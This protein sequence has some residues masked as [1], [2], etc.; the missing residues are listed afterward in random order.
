[1]FIDFS[2]IPTTG[3]D[4]CVQTVAGCSAKKDVGES[5]KEKWYGDI[6]MN[7]AEDYRNI[8]FGNAAEFEKDVLGAKL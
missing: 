4:T 7:L 2:G 8:A 5:P 6:Y 3:P 1:M